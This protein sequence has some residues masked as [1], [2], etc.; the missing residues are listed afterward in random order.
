MDERG[1]AVE[2]ALRYPFA[3]PPRSYVL[4]D[5]GAVAPGAVEVD[6][7]SRVPLLAYG[8]NA[9]PEVLRRK[10]GAASADPVPVVLGRLLDLDVVYSA[11]LAAY[12]SVPATLRR[13]PGTEAATFV[14]YLTEEQLRLV[15]ATE[16]NY[17]LERLE[18]GCRLE[19]GA[20][21]PD[22]LAFLS[23]HGCLLVDGTEVALEAVAAEGRRF[24][25]MSQRAVLEHVRDVL[26]PGQ[27]LER[28]VAA[29]AA[30]EVVHRGL[31]ES[32]ES[33]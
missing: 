31:L 24:P 21:Q 3:V 27:E 15:A 32:G 19:S 9:A 12:G 13:S 25:A 33:P 7:S 28:F 14:A 6:S 17:A 20:E 1:E 26:R 16:P 22:A 29:C 30:A 10:L 2:G 8:S 11:H 18:L 23:H 5:E 4:T